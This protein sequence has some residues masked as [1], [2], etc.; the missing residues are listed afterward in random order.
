[1]KL[2]EKLPLFVGICLPLFLILYVAITA[3]IPSLLVKPKYNFIYAEGYYNDY[4]I[5]VINGKIS[6]GPRYANKTYL[7]AQ[8]TLFLYDVTN[9]KSTQIS[10]E[11]AYS[12]IID[13]SSKSL[14]G[15][16]VGRRESDISY[17][18]FFFG[19]YDRGTY[20]MGRGLNQKITGRDYYNFKFVG[21]IVNE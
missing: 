1:M 18:P 14:D 12:Y 8:P 16:T 17:F 13:P 19:S 5:S 10:L 7:S 3:Y 21:W 11:Q 6:I 15:F 20:L 4:S 2:K 9:D